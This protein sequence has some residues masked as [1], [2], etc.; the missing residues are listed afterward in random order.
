MTTIGKVALLCAAIALGEP[1]VAWAAPASDR[2]TLELHSHLFMKEGM[3][4]MSTGDFNGPLR[5]KDWKSL[6]G[7]Q[8][9]PEALER[10]EI[11]LIVVALYAHPLFTLNLRDSIRS[12]IRLAED[13]VAKHPGWIIVRDARQARDAL[14]HGKRVM[15]LA[16]EGA[17]GIIEDERDLKEFVDEKGIRIVTLLHLTDDRFGGVAF[18]S[19]IKALASPLAWL[20]QLLMPAYDADGVRINGNGLSFEG[21]EM[22]EQLVKRHVWIDLAHASDRSQEAL[23][24][25]LKGLPLLYTHTTLR[26]YL[27]AERGVTMAQLERVRQSGGIVGLI[28][29]ED[30]LEGTRVPSGYCPEGGAP[31][32]G[33]SCEGGIPALATQYTEMA[34]AL[35][36]EQVGLGSDTNGGLKHLKP[37]GP[38]GTG[39]DRE[40]LWNLG[41]EAQ[42]W[43]ALEKSGAPV[44]WPR[45]RMID[46]FLEAWG[47][48]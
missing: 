46:R 22:A 17:S 20:T 12:Q 18:L 44:P 39:I 1:S 10:S 40:G 24:P 23:V 26:K 41:Q 29:S 43:D 2:L 15:V 16:L 19:G 7:N 42:V 28:P 47:K 38:V 31:R 30:M 35:S 32:Q 37:S 27:A 34:R 36:P 6:F 8:A 14:A 3:G 13:F 21:K 5:A 11:G 33:E 45:R 25:L 48:I 9:N 4:W